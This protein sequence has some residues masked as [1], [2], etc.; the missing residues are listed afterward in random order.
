MGRS[1]T[2]RGLHSEL[3]VIRFPSGG[4]RLS[5]T[6]LVLGGEILD[7]YKN[8]SLH[9]RRRD[10]DGDGMM[11]DIVGLPKEIKDCKLLPFPTLESVSCNGKK[12][13]NKA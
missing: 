10:D 13:S 3:H 2:K 11:E 6:F 7:N 1:F 8:P 5:I 9:G 4:C 12:A